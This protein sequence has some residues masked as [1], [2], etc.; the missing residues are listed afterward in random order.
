[1]VHYISPYS[2]EKNIGQAINRA[3]RNTNYVQQDWFVLTDHDTLWLLPDTKAH[4]EAILAET[5]YDVLG[6]MTN[7]IRSAEQLIGGQ[8]CLD[9]RI[10][11]HI[12]LAQECFRNAGKM[13][14]P[15]HG[16]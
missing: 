2:I 3:V 7:R 15:E 6:C 11:A 4:V 1:M 13:V 16:I 8:F 9:D 12:T 10:S 5:G 14:V